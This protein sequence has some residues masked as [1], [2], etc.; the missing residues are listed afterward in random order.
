MALVD[1][2]SGAAVLIRDLARSVTDAI[3]RGW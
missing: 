3:T 1:A 2:A